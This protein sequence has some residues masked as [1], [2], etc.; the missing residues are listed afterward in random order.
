MR[1]R[2]RATEAWPY[3]GSTVGKH[4]RRRDDAPAS[5]LETY[6]RIRKPMPPPEQVQADR[7]RRMLEDDARRE[8][9]EASRRDDSTG[10]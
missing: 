6:R 1:S 7:R 2:R 4:K 3:D 10:R 8:I 5:F 9:E